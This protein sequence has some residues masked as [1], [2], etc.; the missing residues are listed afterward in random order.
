MRLPWHHARP[1]TPELAFR[2]ALGARMRQARIEL[3]MKQRHLAD[4]LGIK[5]SA[6]S[7]YEAGSRTL[8]LKMLTRITSVLGIQVDDLLLGA[9][10][11]EMNEVGKA[12]E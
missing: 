8:S 10:E 2:I 4:E 5:R 9:L 11:L 1:M 3:G 12:A 6:V 7:R